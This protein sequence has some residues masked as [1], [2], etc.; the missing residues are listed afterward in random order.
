MSS[1]LPASSLKLESAGPQGGRSVRTEVG[2]EDRLW[3]AL[4]SPE[5]R[6]PQRQRTTRPAW[7]SPR[8][9]FHGLEFC[10]I[11]CWPNRGLGE[12][13]RAVEESSR[14]PQGNEDMATPRERAKQGQS[15]DGPRAEGWFPKGKTGPAGP[16]SDGTQRISPAVSAPA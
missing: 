8:V 9:G 2:P 6:I 12:A 1:S 4:C 15:A 16:A 3:C 10:V 13:K 14:L 5:T 7:F 11:I